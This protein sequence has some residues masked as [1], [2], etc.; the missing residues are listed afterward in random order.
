MQ[1]SFSKGHVT[2]LYNQEGLQGICCWYLSVFESHV[3][4][5]MDTPSQKVV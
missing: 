1:Q 3:M 5:F 2:V 4:A